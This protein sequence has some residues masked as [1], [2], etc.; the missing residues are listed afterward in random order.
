VLIC[1]I[2]L[3]T[4]VRDQFNTTGTID[5]DSLSIHTQPL[6]EIFV[7][8]FKRLRTLSTI[9]LPADS[10]NTNKFLNFIL[11][12]LTFN[13]QCVEQFPDVIDLKPIEF[14]SL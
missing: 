1:I 10:T 9:L 5:V 4:R 12:N 14:L 6:D 13:P 3:Y 11:C 2:I 8:F 7:N